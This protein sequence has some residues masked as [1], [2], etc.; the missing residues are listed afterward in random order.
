ML[1]RHMG[2][3]Q[4]SNAVT[5]SSREERNCSGHGGRGGSCPATR[6][7]DIPQQYSQELQ[8]TEQVPYACHSCLA[9]E[10]SFDLL[11]R[12][13]AWRQV[14]AHLQWSTPTTPS[15]L[16]YHGCRSFQFPRRTHMAGEWCSAT[17]LKDCFSKRLRL[18]VSRLATH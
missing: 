8:N 9:S 5:L 12:C 13:H 4:V 6:Y 10:K 18:G 7:T 14:V 11:H 2:K 17:R 1:R 3:A 16:P 15:L